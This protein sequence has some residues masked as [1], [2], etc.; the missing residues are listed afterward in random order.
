MN[1]SIV[2]IPQLLLIGAGLAYCQAPPPTINLLGRPYHLGSYNQRDKP[3]WEFIAP[4][5]TID[6]WKTLVTII[7]RTDAHT[8]P[9]LDR[10][11]E[12]IM[13]T[14]KSHGGKIL[15]AKTMVD[16]AGAPYNYMLAAFDEPA[17]HRYEFNFIKMALGPKNVYVAIYGVHITDPT[18]Y[19]AKAKTF[20]TQHSGESGDAISNLPVPDVAKWPRKVF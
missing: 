17:K 13:Q 9:E 11:G 16:P 3:M 7:D 18:D 14:Y 8:R 6:N 2:F 4:G 5:E 20:L 12:G 19:L 10:V 15:M 1:S